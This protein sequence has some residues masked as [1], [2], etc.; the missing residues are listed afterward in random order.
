LA[1]CPTAMHALAV[2]HETPYSAV[3]PVPAG[4]AWTVQV[5]P[6]HASAIG[7]CLPELLP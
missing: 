2:T 3:F 6:F 7:I 1:A 5:L 4:V